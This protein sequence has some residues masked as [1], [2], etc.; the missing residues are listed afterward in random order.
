MNAFSLC[1]DYSGDRERRCETTN[2]PVLVDRRNMRLARLVLCST[3]A[4]FR[5]KIRIGH[6]QRWV[7]HCVSPC[8]FAPF[9]RSYVHQDRLYGHIRWPFCWGGF[10]AHPK[11]RETQAQCMVSAGRVLC[12]R[13]PTASGE[14]WQRGRRRV[15]SKIL[16]LLVEDESIICCKAWISETIVLSGH[17]N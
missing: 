6:K 9:L 5:P 17:L 2:P 8:F 4:L 13:M 15:I 7:R 10:G 14:I 16:G 3:G 1:R 11:L 12:A